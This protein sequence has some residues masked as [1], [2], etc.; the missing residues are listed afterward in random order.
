MITEHS[1]AQAPDMCQPFQPSRPNQ[2]CA[3]IVD[4]DETARN[5]LS[6][7]DPHCL[8]VSCV[9]VFVVVVVCLFLFV[10]FFVFCCFFL[11]FCFVFLCFF[12][13]FFLFFS[14]RLIPLFALV[15][16]SKFK[17]GRVLFRTQG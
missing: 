7:Q 9:C 17:N 5:E 1:P 11:F 16:K 14:L 15:D 8:P 10:F 4:P 3:N 12:F 13:F 2:Y 6:N